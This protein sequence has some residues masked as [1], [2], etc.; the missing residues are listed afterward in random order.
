MRIL[1]SQTDKL[2]ARRGYLIW[3]IEQVQHLSVLIDFCRQMRS[4]R[5]S[6]SHDDL[7]QCVGQ[8]RQP[9][10]L[11]S[12]LTEVGRRTNQMDVVSFFLSTDI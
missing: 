3:R 5:K 1:H 6:H 7:G 11:V 4:G 10:I 2:P 12:H 9:E 8:I